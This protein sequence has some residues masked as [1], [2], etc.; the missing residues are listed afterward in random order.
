MRSTACLLAVFGLAVATTDV[1]T[2]DSCDELVRY[3]D[4]AATGTLL[5]EVTANAEHI[6]TLTKEGRSAS[7]WLSKK[8]WVDDSSGGTAI[9]HLLRR[10]YKAEGS[11]EGVVG[12]ELWVHNRELMWRMGG[13]HFDK[14][15]AQ[16]KLQF[17]EKKENRERRMSF[18]LRGTVTYLSD[19][20]GPTIVYDQR[21]S[22]DLESLSPITP[23]SGVAVFPMKGRH[24]TFSGDA[25]HQVRGDYNLTKG[26]PAGCKRLTLL[27]NWWEH[28]IS[29]KGLTELPGLEEYNPP[30]GE[31]VP[32]MKKVEIKTATPT[33]LKDSTKH[34]VALFPTPSMKGERSFHFDLPTTCKPACRVD[35]KDTKT[36]FSN[37][38]LIDA[39][40]IVIAKE[41]FS[42]SEA[43]R[44]IIFVTMPELFRETAPVAKELAEKYGCKAYIIDALH[45][46]GFAS[47]LRTPLAEVPTAA[48]F[49]GSV[50]R[51]PAGESVTLESVGA[52]VDSAIEYT[53]KGQKIGDPYAN[54]IDLD[55]WA[56]EG[57]KISSAT[58]LNICYERTMERLMSTSGGKQTRCLFLLPGDGDAAEFS[59]EISKKWDQ[60]AATKSYETFTIS[61]NDEKDVFSGFKFEI[62]N[63]RPVFISLDPETQQATFWGKQNE[64]KLSSW[65]NAL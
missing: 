31:K 19:C 21:L 56:S 2:D 58:Q 15:E 1:C 7:F 18:P 25:Y 54:T 49:D 51:L 13:P 8:D 61:A 55:F 35:W 45:S 16:Y 26:S 60:K 3:Y 64:D 14:D 6:S 39:S 27:V 10:I 40:N 24:L 53:L 37:V 29:S 63:E 52:L 62:P 11:Q 44:A 43:G 50:H 33:E 30:Q 22:A 20:G 9:H 46:P 65:L 17:K 12:A 36:G 47:I 5:D 41:A 4:N 48:V 28:E 59:E 57:Q 34:T 32:D 38:A 23:E 42:P